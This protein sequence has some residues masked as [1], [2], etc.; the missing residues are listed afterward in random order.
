VWSSHYTFMS[1]IILKG[2]GEFGSRCPVWSPGSMVEGGL[3]CGQA[4]LVLEDNNSQKVWRLT[5]MK[6]GNI[7]RCAAAIEFYL[8][9][10]GG[11]RSLVRSKQYSFFGIII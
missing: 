2:S 7:M 1:I 11:R 8:R 10:P 3:K 6:P 5:L 9:V 4:L